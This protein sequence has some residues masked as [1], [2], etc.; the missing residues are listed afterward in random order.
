MRA[1]SS[2]EIERFRQL[3]MTTFGLEF[4]DDASGHLTCVFLDRLRKSGCP[5]A[6]AYLERIADPARSRAEL[7]QL[8]ADLTVPETYFFRHAEQY[9]AFAEVA[10]RDRVAEAR[11]QGRL[12]RVL[13]AGCASGEEAYSL[14]AIVRDTLG[15]AAGGDVE[16]LGIDIN[17]IMLEKARHA[18]YSGWSLRATGE[19]LRKRHFRSDGREFV[20]QDALRRSVRFEERNLVTD[21]GIFAPGSF[22]V[23]FCRNVMIYFSP[24]AIKTMVARIARSLVPHGYLFLGPSETLR[25]VSDDF[26]LCNTDGAF[27]YRRAREVRNRGE[28]A[29]HDRQVGRPLA[30]SSGHIARGA[31][32]NEPMWFGTIARSSVRVAIIAR[33]LRRRPIRAPGRSDSSAQ[34]LSPQ[35][36]HQWDL[37]GAMESLRHERFSEVLK[38][39]DALPEGSNSDPDTLLLRAAALMGSGEIQEAERICSRVLTLAP[40]NPSAYHML[41]LCREKSGDGSGAADH[42]RI[43]VNLDPWFAMPR[44]HLGLLARRTEDYQ[45]ARRE[46]RRA[47]LLLLNETPDRIVLFGGGFTRDALVQCCA[48]MLRACGGES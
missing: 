40:P 22:D 39:I 45:T 13:S 7:R 6:A 47:R 4:A 25:G 20:V 17:P 19:E 41:A 38:T 26:T 10:L 43:A 27:Y 2:Q 9:Q 32:S 24:A 5:N 36:P 14:A 3:V 42:D 44:L 46:L 18:R 16:I 8:A 28:R 33:D 29:S 48:S 15:P 37:A 30:R 23:V 34:P 31:I 35:T 11:R 12:M 1:V 21:E